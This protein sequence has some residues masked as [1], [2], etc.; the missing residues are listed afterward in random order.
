MD[1]Y[2]EE[3]IINIGFGKDISVRELAELVRRIIGFEGRIEWDTNKPDGT[4]RKLLDSSRIFEL[5]WKPEIRLEEGLRLAYE[6]F[7]R[8]NGKRTA[9]VTEAGGGEDHGPAS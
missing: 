8:R 2:S 3:S 5:G 4:P 1:H 9:K 7:L 6:D